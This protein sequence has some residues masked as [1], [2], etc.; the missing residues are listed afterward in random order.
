MEKQPF[1]NSSHIKNMVIFQ[2]SMFVYLDATQRLFCCKDHEL[3]L[4]SVSQECLGCCIYQSCPALLYCKTKKIISWCGLIHRKWVVVKNMFVR[5]C[6]CKKASFV[7]WL[8]M[9]QGFFSFAFHCAGG[10]FLS[11]KNQWLQSIRWCL[12]CATRKRVKAPMEQLQ[13]SFTFVF[14]CWIPTWYSCAS[15]KTKLGGGF[16]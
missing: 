7:C 11:W 2:L 5:S 15:E 13:K 8:A 14:W 16:K 9:T 10:R 1:K 3:N 12:N 4:E 6:F